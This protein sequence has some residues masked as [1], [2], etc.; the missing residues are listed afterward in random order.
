MIIREY[1]AYRDELSTQNGVL[2][3]GSRIIIPNS[4]RPEMLVRIHSSHLGA[5]SCLPKARDVFYWPNMSNEIRDKVGQCS[6]CNEYQQSH[7]TH[8]IPE[9]PWSRVA[10]DIFTLNGEDYLITV[11]FNSDFCMEG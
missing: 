6:A 4:M 10:M 3:K 8:E 11:D 7:M 1:W 2:F 9:F 5:E